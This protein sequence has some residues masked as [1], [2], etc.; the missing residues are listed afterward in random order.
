[1]MVRDGNLPRR[2]GSRVTGGVR[3]IAP[4]TEE[5]AAYLHTKATTMGHLFTTTPTPSTEEN[6]R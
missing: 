4:S 1:M 3:I 2:G 5:N 6:P